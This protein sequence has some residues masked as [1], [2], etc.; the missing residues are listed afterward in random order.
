MARRHFWPNFKN[1]GHEKPVKKFAKN[2]LEGKKGKMEGIPLNKVA[3][4]QNI[5]N[6]N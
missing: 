6:R 1:F 3:T 2:S 4:A 5:K